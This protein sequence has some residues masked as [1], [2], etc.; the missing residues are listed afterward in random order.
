MSAVVGV[1]LA[2]GLARRMGGG[3]KGLQLLGGRP[4]LAHVIERLGPQVAALVLNVNGE[5]SAFA[6]F[7]LPIMP[8]TVSGFAGP[9]AGVLAGLRWA[10]AHWPQASEIVTVPGDGPFLPLDLVARLS[11]ARVAQGAD[12]ACAVSDGQAYPVVGLW[13]LA[14]A[15]DLERAMVG[16]DIR[17]VDVWTQRHRLAQVAFAGEPVDPFFNVNRPEDLALAERLLAGVG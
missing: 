7:G 16:E 8:D 14:L 5:S 9:L 17:K 1:I 11:A 10:E 4:I 13:P 15:D 12:L 2:G 3:H 6:S